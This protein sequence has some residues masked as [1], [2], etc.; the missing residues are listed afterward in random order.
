MKKKKALSPIQ[1]LVTLFADKSKKNGKTKYH[2]FKKEVFNNA[3]IT[4]RNCDSLAE[5]NNRAYLQDTIS[6][7]AS[8]PRIFTPSP[9]ETMFPARD[10][11]NRKFR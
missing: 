1:R 10:S 8:M 7:Q 5:F 2:V 11:M 6:R 3:K 9:H 4:L